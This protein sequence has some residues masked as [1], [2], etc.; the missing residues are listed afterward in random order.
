MSID[1]CNQVCLKYGIME[2]ATDKI[3]KLMAAYG[4]KNHSEL[5]RKIGESRQVISLDFKKKSIHR[6]V[7]YA[8][9]FDMDPKDL[10]K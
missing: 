2:L 9:L 8:E 6:V 5:G 7:K 1:K 4:I 3:E 10:I